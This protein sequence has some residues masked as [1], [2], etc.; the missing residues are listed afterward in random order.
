LACYSIP[1]VILAC[2]SVERGEAL[3]REFNAEAKADGRQAP[4]CDVMELDLSS[5]ASIR[6]FADAWDARNLPLHVLL[7]NAG[8]F[9]MSAARAETVDGFEM[10]MGTNHLGHFLLTMLL[11]PSLRKGTEQ[12]CRPA[13]VVNVSS[14]L[15]LM[16]SLNKQDPNLENGSYASLKAYAQ[17]KLA[18]ILFAAELTRRGQGDV[19]AVA[20]HPG[21][22][23]REVVR[24]LPPII[25]KAY[26]TVMGLILLSPAQGARCSVYCSTSPDL[27]SAKLSG[28]TYYD[29]NCAPGAT[30]KAGKDVHLASWLW[31]WSAKTVGLKVG[32]DLKSV[33]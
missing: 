20:L 6:T 16:G 26:R 10:H 5:I 11:L 30:S 17:S 31:K 13:R 32:E 8:L 24:S 15:H 7:N 27:D 29:S 9:A 22:V 23:A 4:N 19:I 25:Q 28:I 14:R 18:Q 1:A 2:R 21:E 12:L 3:K 33:N